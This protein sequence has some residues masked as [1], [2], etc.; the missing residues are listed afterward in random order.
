MTNS[1]QS[2]PR[3][4][5]RTISN[6]ASG[7]AVTFLETA[8]ESNGSRVVMQIQV[9]PGGGPAPHAHWTQT[10]VFEGVEGIVELIMDKGRITLAPGDRVT[11]PAGVLHAFRNPAQTAATIRVIA[12]PAG[13]IEWGLRAAFYMMREGLLP[14]QPLV[15]ALLL[16]RSDLYLPPLPQWLYR[17]MIGMLAKLAEWGG[18]EDVLA[19]YG[20]RPEE[21]LPGA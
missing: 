3:E 21:P 20:A 13:N 9:A 5:W 17:P 14:R 8:E 2:S 12:S 11:V 7:E 18:R 10:E 15:A 6:A 1:D 4:A 16:Q 19:R